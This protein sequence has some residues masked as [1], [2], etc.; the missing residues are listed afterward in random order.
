MKS[1]NP[2][3]LGNLLS[4]TLEWFAHFL[5]RPH[6]CEGEAFFP[7]V[8]LREGSGALDVLQVCRIDHFRRSRAENEAFVWEGWKKVPTKA[9]SGKG[10]RGGERRVT[11]EVPG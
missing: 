7:K 6:P 5:G 3:A 11:G 8:K 2:H 9:E 4:L 1:D 10:D